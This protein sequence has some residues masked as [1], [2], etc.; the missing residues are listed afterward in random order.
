MTLQ[1][2]AALL[3]AA[4]PAVMPSGRH[5]A[6]PTSLHVPID[7]QAPERCAQAAL[8]MGLGCY[9]AEAAAL[10]DVDRSFDPVL[11]RSLITDLV[12][13][14][15]PIVLYQ[16]GRAPL[17]VAHFG[18]VTGWD[19]ARAAFILNDGRARPRVVGSDHLTRRWRTVGLQAL[20]IRRSAP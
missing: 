13:G 6:A 16:N 1:V 15:P 11:R 4:S 8:E 10:H 3:V 18:V 9:G 19:P 14:V 20:I 2:L 5:Q 17:T 12:A 7:V